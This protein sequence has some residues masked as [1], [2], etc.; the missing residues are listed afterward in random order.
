MMTYEIDAIELLQNT[1]RRIYQGT[2]RRQMK[3]AVKEYLESYELAA[4][5]LCPFY[6][7]LVCVSTLR[8]LDECPDYF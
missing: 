8:M 3:L 5:E 2:D 4:L 7:G 1:E 6:M